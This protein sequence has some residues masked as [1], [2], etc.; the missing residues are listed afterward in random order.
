MYLC[1]KKK[2]GLWITWLSFR[3]E[4]VLKWLSFQLESTAKTQNHGLGIFIRSLVGLDHEA[5]MQ[6]FSE[7]INGTTVTPNQIEFIN[8]VVQELTQAGVMDSSRL[9]E[10]PFT[11]LSAQGPIGIFPPLKVQAMVQVLEEIRHSAVG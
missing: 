7:F 8:M 3:L 2:Q 4:F 10:S 1:L 6:A 9:F 5:A 11:D